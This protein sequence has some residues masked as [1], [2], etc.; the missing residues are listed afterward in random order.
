MHLRFHHSGAHLMC[1]PGTSP[2]GTLHAAMMPVPVYPAQQW[3]TP[4]SAATSLFPSGMPPS[5]TY[6]PAVIPPQSS[7]TPSTSL[8]PPHAFSLHWQVFSVIPPGVQSCQSMGL[9]VLT[10]YPLVHMAPVHVL[11]TY[12]LVHMVPAPVLIMYLQVHMA[13]V[14]FVPPHPMVRGDTISI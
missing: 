7:E 1:P 5:C 13:L 11:I 4:I 9:Q 2:M 8:L 12:L 14:Q 6:C 10:I 3:P